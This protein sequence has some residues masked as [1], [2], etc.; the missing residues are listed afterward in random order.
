MFLLNRPI[1]WDADG[2]SYEADQ[3]H[4]EIISRDLGLDGNTQTTPVP[5]KRQTLEQVESPGPMLEPR[6]ATMY[7]AIVARGN[8]LSQDRSDIKYA[9][10]ELSRGMSQPMDGDLNRLK[11]LGK[12]LVGHP[13]LV[14]HFR[15]QVGTKFLDVWVDTDFAG[16]LRTRRSTNGGV[17]T[18]G[19][20]VIKHWS[21]TQATVALSS[22]EAE[23]YGMVK[24]ASVALGLRSMLK[25]LGVDVRIRL[26]TDAAAA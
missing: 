13:R 2:I 23:Y 21:S 26:R 18:I 6:A 4:V 20:H 10:K 15:P 11:R 5:Y 14:Q 16:C 22:G 8:Y 24:G 19:S 9:V 12:Y 17:I 1:Q 3:R 25:D 7:R